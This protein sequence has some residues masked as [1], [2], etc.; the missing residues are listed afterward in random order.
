MVFESYDMVH[1]NGEFL[2][3]K[4]NVWNLSQRPNPLCL[5]TGI[6]IC[7]NDALVLF[8]HAYESK[9]KRI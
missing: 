8:A 6:Y 4:M 9:L 7:F 5:T 1:I 3:F 2:I